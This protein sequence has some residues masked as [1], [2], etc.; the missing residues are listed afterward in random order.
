[1]RQIIFISLFATLFITACKKE[2]IETKAPADSDVNKVTINAPSPCTGN[3]W[4]FHSS[5]DQNFYGF[6]L[7]YN[8]KLYRFS[9][10]VSLGGEGVIYVY[11]GTSITSIPSNIPYTPAG[12]SYFF[13]FIIGDKAYL[14][15]YSVT[16]PDHF[17]EYD[18]ITNTWTEKA[19]FPGNASQGAATFTIGNKG[20]VFGGLN[21]DTPNTMASKQTW[22]YD[23]QSDAWEQKEDLPGLYGRVS[24]EGFSI[25][26]KGY[27]VNGGYNYLNNGTPATAYLK[28]L[29][30]YDA[31]ADH[32][33]YKT[34]FP[35]Q[36]RWNTNVF[37]TSGVAYAGGGSVSGSG[38]NDYYKYNPGTNAWTQIASPPVLTNYNPSLLTFSLNGKGYIH[39]RGKVSANHDAVVYK[40]IPQS[41]TGAS[42]L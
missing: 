18:F 6:P 41:C 15:K 38:F 20:Y 14:R 31:V 8:N 37:V 21:Y 26:N 40:Y 1:M 33:T 24:A 25:G 39:Y 11:D 19:N 4:V 7:V 23:P 29:L 16:G 12:T 42:P 13:G 28:S 3:N 5:I 36:A 22:E 10:S 32:W 35:G 17:Y 27:C 2:A 9:A 30:Q 34:A